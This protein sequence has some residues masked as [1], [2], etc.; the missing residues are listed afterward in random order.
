M[1]SEVERV[2]KEAVKAY[3]CISQEGLRKAAGNL[4]KNSQIPFEIQTEYHLNTNR[5]YHC[6]IIKKKLTTNN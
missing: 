5:C 1:Y 6:Q 3:I 4:R 2:G